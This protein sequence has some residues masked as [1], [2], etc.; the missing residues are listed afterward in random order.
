MKQL[1]SNQLL[2]RRSVHNDHTYRGFQMISHANSSRLAAPSLLTVSFGR[3]AFAA[4]YYFDYECGLDSNVGTSRSTSW[5]R[6]PHMKR[7]SVGSKY[8][9]STGDVFIFQGDVARA[10]A[11]LPMH[12][13]AGGSVRSPL[14]YGGE[15]TWHGGSASELVCQPLTN[16]EEN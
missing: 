1:E 4:I 14:C 9:P 6:H 16:P 13:S 2:N 3:T 12:V 5:K 10:A 8:T 11:A 7:R 15:A